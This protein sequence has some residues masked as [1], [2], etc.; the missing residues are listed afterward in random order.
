MKLSLITT[1][2]IL[3][4]NSVFAM[5]FEQALELGKNSGVTGDIS[6][7]Q[8]NSLTDI[9][10]Y[11]QADVD[12]AKQNSLYENPD[13]IS[14]TATQ[15][16]GN[17]PA[18]VFLTESYEQR[19]DFVITE[20]DPL[21]QQA[22]LYRQSI[23]DNYSDCTTIEQCIEYGNTGS[24]RNIQTCD[25]YLTVINKTCSLE[26]TGNA[27]FVNCS[28][29]IQNA[30]IDRNRMDKMEVK[31]STCDDTNRF[32]VSVNAW[33]GQGACNGPINFTI[34]A[35]TITDWQEMATLRPHWNG[36]CR[37]V[38]VSYKGG[39]STSCAESDTPSCT[40]RCDFSFRFQYGLSEW[41]QDFSFDY[42][43]ARVVFFSESWTDNCQGYS[44]SC[45]L[46][47]SRCTQT[48]IKN[49]DGFDITRDCWK[50]ERTYTCKSDWMDN[51]Q[52]L[53]NQGC[54]QISS[55]CSASDNNGECTM[56]QN[57]YNCQSTETGCTKTQ[58]VVSCNNEI[59]CLNPTDCFDTSNIPDQNFPNAVSQMSVLEEMGKD[60]DQTT[61]QVFGGSAS[62]CSK[63]I[64]NSRDCCDVQG[65]LIDA[66]VTGCS[67]TEVDLAQKR[68]AGVCV[69]V[70]SYCDKSTFFGACLVKKETYCCFNSKLSRI[71]NEQ[72]RP[73]IG[74][75]WG[76]PESPDCSGMT[77][78]E[79]QQI[80]FSRIDFSEFYADINAKMPIADEL[81]QNCSGCQ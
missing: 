45:V 28:V 17:N 23:M 81:S 54:A 64:A 56:Y 78:E 33:G 22:D 3:I 31:I 55:S 12:A 19:P 40:D 48:G 41:I 35:T 4:F 6:S 9:P 67:Q 29:P 39:C 38:S 46:V 14:D 80:D 73:Q 34:P 66:N 62:K 8:Q 10:N 21:V 11:N 79:I 26:L 47:N 53:I 18:S 5:D 61:M 58:T 27:E 49:I 20:E 37:Y 63:W 69:N 32:T 75:T 44:G 72:G 25:K 50:T 57:T 42:K 76:S 1:G 36:E 2:V 65:I 15:E 77:V 70:G 24:I 71:V 59:R 51:C 30:V 7:I 13:T 68:D 16:F 43:P 60:T 52:D 74:K